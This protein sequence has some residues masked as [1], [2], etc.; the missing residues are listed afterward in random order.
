VRVG[1]VST[2]SRSRDARQDGAVSSELAKREHLPVTRDRLV[3]YHQVHVVRLDL[4]AV[5]YACPR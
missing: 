2:S 5:L 1:R 4:D 3:S